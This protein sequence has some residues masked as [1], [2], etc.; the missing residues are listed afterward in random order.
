METLFATTGCK[1]WAPGVGG[2][3]A[4]GVA[5][6][7]PHFWQNLPSTAAPQFAQKAIIN[8]SVESLYP[9]SPGLARPYETAA[10]AE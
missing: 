5:T 2:T 8:R 9:K 3:G 6:G 7:A 4:P 10:E 1:G